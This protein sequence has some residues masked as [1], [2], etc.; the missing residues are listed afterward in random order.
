M[1]IERSQFA[2]QSLRKS[3]HPAFGCCIIGLSRG[4]ENPANGRDVDDL[5]LSLGNHLPDDCFAAI[6]KARQ[7][8]AN[9]GV[10]VLITHQHEKII[11][12]EAHVI[13]KDINLPILGERIL[14]HLSCLLKLGHIGFVKADVYSPGFDS[15]L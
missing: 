13:D 2:S 12:N 10:P 8:C 11:S 6:E 3:D 7:V 1:D 15:L 4:A 9:E 5:S 14:D